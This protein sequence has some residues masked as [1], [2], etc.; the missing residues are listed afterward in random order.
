MHQR[1]SDGFT[2]VELLVVIAIIGILIA[3]LLPAVQAA[4]ES[5]RRVSCQ[6]NLK[7]IGLAVHQYQI[8]HR[9]YPPAFLM[10]PG[11]FQRGSWSVQ[12]RLLPFLEKGN[13]Y[14]RI[15]LQTDWHLQLDSQVP[16]MRISTYL[17]P[18]ES[19]AF[20]R[21][22]SGLPYVHPL[23]YGMNFGTWFIFDPIEQESGDGVFSVNQMLRPRW[24]RDGLSN[25]LCSAEVRAYTSYIR[26]S[27][28]SSSNI[29][30]SP[31]YFEGIT[32]ELKLGHD[33]TRNTGHTVWCDG[34]VHHSGFTTVYTPNTKVN[35]TFESQRFDIDFNSQ[36]EGRSLDK[37]TFAAVT[38]RSYHSG[39]VNVVRMDGSVDTVSNQV[40]L[41]VWRAMGTRSGDEIIS[42]Q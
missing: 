33:I 17:C 10:N 3:I 40:E 15:D 35:Y 14:D 30:D 16:A 37:K 42:D 18:N 38:S 32:G 29:P 36:Q 22:K 28:Y 27:D 23:T 19:H 2:L 12:G 13:A 4:R 41:K 25:T 24:I 11:E 7:Q 31:D 8:A 39:I 34:R 5:A 1:S 20:P 9:V 21:Y 6:N 26:N